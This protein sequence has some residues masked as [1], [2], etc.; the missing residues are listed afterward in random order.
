[1]LSWP[2]AP[3]AAGTSWYRSHLAARRLGA[4]IVPRGV[5]PAGRDARTPLTCMFTAIGA[6]PWS[7]ATRGENE[8]SAESVPVTVVRMSI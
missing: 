7:G 3:H 2:A 5:E 6:A 8:S 1:M 4:R